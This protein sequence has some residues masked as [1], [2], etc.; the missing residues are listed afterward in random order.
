[1]RP[2]VERAP[3]QEEVCICGKTKFANAAES[4]KQSEESRLRQNHF[5]THVVYI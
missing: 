3:P 4:E 2:L 1:M 5:L